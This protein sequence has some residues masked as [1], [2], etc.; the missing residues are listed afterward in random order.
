VGVLRALGV[1]LKATA[2]LHHPLRGRQ[3]PGFVM[4]GFLNVIGVAALDYELDLDERTR[5]AVLGETSV[6]AFRLD[7]EEFAWRDLRLGGAQLARAR[8]EFIHSYGSCSF[9]EP[10]TDLQALG[11]LT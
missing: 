7:D 4:H 11:M 2:G 10:V 3:A 6:S 5:A 8:A 1:P 9:D